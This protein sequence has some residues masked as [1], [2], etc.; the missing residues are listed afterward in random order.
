[1]DEY[2]YSTAPYSAPPAPPAPPAHPPPPAPRVF[3]PLVLF[4]V[5]VAT[6][7]IAG[8]LY[9]G[10]DIINYPG[11]VLRGVPFSAALLVVLGTH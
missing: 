6:T 3:V 2:P 10:A 4:I 11:Q 7:V 5:T 8:A 1:M 9:Q